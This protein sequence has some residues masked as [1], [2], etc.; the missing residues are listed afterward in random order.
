MPKHSRIPDCHPDQPHHADG[1]CKR[2][3]KREWFRGY[4]RRAKCSE[5]G[6]NRAVHARE[7]C[8]THYFKRYQA[9]SPKGPGKQYGS[10][11]PQAIVRVPVRGWGF[12]G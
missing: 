3:Y 10:V 4:R 7:M 5:P 1:V 12:L 8:R 2:C 6:C 9:T 11:Y